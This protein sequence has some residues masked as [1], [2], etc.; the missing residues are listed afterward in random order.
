MY[1]H[2]VFGSE[3]PLSTVFFSYQMK[4]KLRAKPT[5]KSAEM[6]IQ[7]ALDDRADE[8]HEDKRYAT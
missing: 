7:G 8:D 1:V 5:T 2:V 3:H 4:R 6:K